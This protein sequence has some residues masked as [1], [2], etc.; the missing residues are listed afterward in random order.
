MSTNSISQ[1]DLERKRAQEQYIT[2][3]ATERGLTVAALEARITA[4]LCNPLPED[5]MS[6]LSGMFVFFIFL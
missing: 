2:A 4:D 6:M 5:T 1:L 3:L